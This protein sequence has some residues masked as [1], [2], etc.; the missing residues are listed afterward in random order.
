M[1]LGQ[2]FSFNFLKVKNVEEFFM[3]KHKMMMMN[4]KTYIKTQQGHENSLGI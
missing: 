4:M 3:K 2:G 1:N